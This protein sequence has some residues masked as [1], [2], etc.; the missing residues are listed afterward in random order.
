[1]RDA[2]VLKGHRINPVPNAGIGAIVT[3]LDRQTGTRSAGADPRRPT[4]AFGW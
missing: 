4:Y 3:M 2:L 1:V